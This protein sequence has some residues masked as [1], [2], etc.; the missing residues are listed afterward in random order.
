M[1]NEEL[2]VRPRDCGGVSFTETRNIFQLTLKSSDGPTGIKSLKICLPL[3]FQLGFSVA[4]AKDTT[5]PTTN[6][7]DFNIST[8]TLLVS[9]N[10]L[11]K[12]YLNLLTYKLNFVVLC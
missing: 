7:S 1:N 5:K 6:K 3:K 11:N 8:N 10:E 9:D 4:F 12:T 2:Y